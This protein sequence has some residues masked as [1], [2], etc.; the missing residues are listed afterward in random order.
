MNLSILVNAAV[1]MLLFCAAVWLV[2]RFVRL[3]NPHT[4][5]LV[6]RMAL[7]A[8]LALPV[9]LYFRAAPSFATHLHLPV[10]TVNGVG[11]TGDTPA[12]NLVGIPWRLLLAI[13]LS[14]ALLLLVRLATGL[15][16]LWRICR[17]AERLPVPGDVR[18]SRRV[19][20]PATFGTVVLL[21][22]EAGAWPAGK[23]DAVLA[24]ELAHVRS[25]D[26]CWSWLAQLH[27][28]LFWFT[29]HAWWLRRQ[30]TLLAETT[31]DD[32]VV[33]A[34]HD[35]VAYAE[36][37]LDFA[38]N[39]DNRSVAMSVADS[40]VSKRINRLLSHVPPARELPR[41]ARWAAVALLVP[42]V[43][44][45]ASTTRAAPENPHP[46]VEGLGIAHP[47]V[48][49]D[50]FPAVAKEEQVEGFAILE[51]D[52]DV[53]GQLVDARLVDVQPADPR[54]GFADAALRV[55]RDSKYMNRAQ[56][57]GS[58]RFKVKFALDDK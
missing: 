46:I 42:A 38:R 37:L 3:R 15:V 39:P 10:L 51:V 12:A 14:G 50:Y 40:D 13:Y 16:G 54:F 4:E 52:L 30:L 33:A 55:A 28:A 24:H 9:L 34:R 1:R 26:S 22:V 32:A 43:V 18:V 17:A 47:A 48:T 45:A 53:L 25:R 8:S 56:R 20:S 2:V 49:D 29:P 57:P 58:M 7:L 23:L 6:W 27:H 36:L 11:A 5:A 31:S 35:P 44:F 41:A 21:P 19:H